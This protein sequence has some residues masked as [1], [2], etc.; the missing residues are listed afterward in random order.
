MSNEKTMLAEVFS[1][2][3]EGRKRL[4]DLRKELPWFPGKNIIDTTIDLLPDPGDIMNQILLA[5]E[6]DL[7]DVHDLLHPQIIV[8]LVSTLEDFLWNL[9]L[10]TPESLEENSAKSKYNFQCEEDIRET[11]G[12]LLKTD[13]FLGKNHLE[14]KLNE[15]FQVRHII[16]H[17]G[18]K[19]DEKAIE[20]GP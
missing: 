13:P 12:E 18:G 2:F 1:D 17:K 4:R 16:I 9:Y 7:D 6:S 20:N 10:S 8:F 5:I 15:I 11:F 19:I 3:R 14:E